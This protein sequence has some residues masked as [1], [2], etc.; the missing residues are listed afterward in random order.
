MQQGEVGW[1]GK[2]FTEWARGLCAAG[3]LCSQGCRPG[4]LGRSCLDLGSA[5]LSLLASL[6]SHPHTLLPDDHASPERQPFLP[7][8]FA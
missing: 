2:G 4:S 3:L 1:G 7:R 6:D 8:F 5:R